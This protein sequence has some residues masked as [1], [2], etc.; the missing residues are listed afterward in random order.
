MRGSFD[1]YPNNWGLKAPDS[2]IDHRRVPNLQAFFERK[3]T[4]LETSRNPADYLP[5][6]L[7]TWML[8]GNLPHI[9]IAVARR[10]SDGRRPLIVHNIGAGPAIEDMLFKFPLTG[11]YRYRPTRR[12]STAGTQA[13]GQQQ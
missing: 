4:K 10:S 7:V 8:P 5:G 11:H 9:G 1:R 2:N 12:G 6:D 13:L 3:G